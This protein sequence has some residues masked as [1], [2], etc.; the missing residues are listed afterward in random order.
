MVF[1]M[2]GNRRHVDIVGNML[3]TYVQV[4]IKAA[5]YVRQRYI[6]AHA[7][8]LVG[9]GRK[10]RKD[11]KKGRL[12]YYFLNSWER[13]CVRKNKRGKIISHGIGKVDATRLLR[14]VIRVS[15]FK[16]APTNRSFVAQEYP[17]PYDCHN[18]DLLT[19]KFTI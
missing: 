15:R 5:S 18:R 19:D 4:K 12:Y 3:P 16:E 10:K 6:H 7:V 13:F 11:G 17:V 9:A 8:V 14:N 2:V 1:I